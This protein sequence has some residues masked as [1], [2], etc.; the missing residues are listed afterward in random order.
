MPWYTHPFLE[1]LKTWDL[2]DKRIF[3]YGGGASSLWWAKKARE[4]HTVE[5]DADWCRA[6]IDGRQSNYLENLFIYHRAITDNEDELT[7]PFAQAINE[8]PGLFDI[9]VID[10][11][12]RDECVA[13]ALAKI[14]PGGYI[15]C[16]NWNQD[17]VWESLMAQRL[18]MGFPGEIY[19]QP[20]HTDHNGRPWKTGYWQITMLTFDVAL[21][22]WL[23]PNEVEIRHLLFA[24]NDY[25]SHRPM[26]WLALEK[27][28]PGL[29]VEFGAG[30]GSTPLLHEY[31]IY[32][33]RPFQSFESRQEW[34]DEFVRMNYINKIKCQA[35]KDWNEVDDYIKEPI[36][37][38]FIDCAPGEIRKDLIRKYADS[39]TVIIAH[40]TQASA[41]HDYQMSGALNS[42]KYRCDLVIKG[43][44][45]TTAV[46]NVYDF[47]TWK[48]LKIGH[49]EFI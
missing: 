46:S 19:V 18:L 24:A 39:A 42:L 40:D 22:R 47:K 25:N 12:Y 35:V 20:D 45:Q 49:Y 16:D 32:Q 7:S 15:I 36:R 17:Y 28:K 21:D 2:S 31:C 4:V 29:V 13:L 34:A 6:I 33:N 10:G 14:K 11:S 44:P 38:L 5:A 43:L 30:Y 3:E 37:I 26:L 48:G 8:V 23:S 9:V 27:I 1:V 41:D